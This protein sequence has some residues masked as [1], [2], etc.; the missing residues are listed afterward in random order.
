MIKFITNGLGH[1]MPMNKLLGFALIIGGTLVGLILLWLLNIYWQEQRFSAGTAV[2]F[3]IVTFLIFVIPQWVIGF[4][5][6][7]HKND[8]R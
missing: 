1:E 6:V 4:Y 5:L 7:K 3:I 8:H 2:A